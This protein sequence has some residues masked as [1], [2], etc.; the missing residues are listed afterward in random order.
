MHKADVVVS[1]S[2]LSKPYECRAYLQGLNAV[3]PTQEIRLDKLR[4]RQQLL[5]LH[6][7]SVW[8]LDANIVW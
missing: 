8:Q 7:A 3:D 6:I 1:V 2:L 4:I 5:Q